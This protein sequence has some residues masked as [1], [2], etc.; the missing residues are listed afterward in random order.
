M[1]PASSSRCS[2]IR[3][4]AISASLNGAISTSPR[5]LR[6]MPGEFGAACGKLPGRFGVQLISAVVAHAVEAALELHD[7][8]AAAE[9]AGDAH[10]EG[11]GFGAG[12]DEAHLLGAGDGV[13]QFGGQPDAVFVVR[14]EGEA[15]VEL[16]A[17]RF[18]HVG[19]AVAD[20]HRAGAEQEIDVFAAVDVGDA[21]GV[22]FADDEVAGEVAEA[23]GRQ[24]TLGECADVGGCG[25]CG[26]VHR[27]DPEMAER[28]SVSPSP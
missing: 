1:T 19:V 2:W 9:G 20:E 6:G 11:V 21:A 3:L 14:E 26:V 18:D 7:L 8:V 16:F 15:A 27:F 24:H 10:G 22:A 23:G 5:P 28:L 17:H 12:G 25:K 4:A 13:D